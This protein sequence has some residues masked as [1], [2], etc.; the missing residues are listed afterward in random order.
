MIH[1]DNREIGEDTLYM[2]L[3]DLVKPELVLPKM[4]CSSKNEL[5]AKLIDQIYSTKHELP[6]PKEEVWNSIDIREQI[7]GTLLPSGLSVPHARLRDYDGI[8]LAIGIPD[9]A[10]FQ[11]G[12][13]I[14]MMA[15]LITSQ[16]GG[17]FY[18]PVLAALTK[19]SKNTEFFSRLCGAVNSKDFINILRENNPELA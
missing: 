6:F 10:L 3:L 14:H 8:I 9:E 15:L 5:I 16:S 1:I 7:G 2:T 11:G 19:I 18:L 13:Q 4:N 17:Q 12:H